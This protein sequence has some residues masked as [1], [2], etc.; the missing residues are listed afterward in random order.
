[1]RSLP[2]QG[3]TPWIPYT[4]NAYAVFQKRGASDFSPSVD[5]EGRIAVSPLHPRH[6]SPKER[7]AEICDLLAFA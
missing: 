1:M 2:P 5:P 4:K 7:P 6:M 3:W